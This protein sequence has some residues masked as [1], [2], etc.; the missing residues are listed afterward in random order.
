MPAQESNGHSA[1]VF[2]RRGLVAVVAAAIVAGYCEAA[3]ISVSMAADRFL[4]STSLEPHPLANQI[5]AVV[6]VNLPLLIAVAIWMLVRA[7]P[8]PQQLAAL[9]LG[10]V[11][12]MTVFL[13][14]I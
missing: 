2:A 10:L 8:R 5:A 6:L 4:P 11:V 3:L 7:R 1:S 13:L 14:T 9:A 12:W